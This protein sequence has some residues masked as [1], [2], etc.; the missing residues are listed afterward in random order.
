MS[1]KNSNDHNVNN[2]CEINESSVTPTKKKKIQNKPSP[3]V[4]DEIAQNDKKMTKKPKIAKKAKRLVKT[5]DS[6]K[7][8]PKNDYKR[9]FT[10]T[11]CKKVLYL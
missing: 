11:E 6:G 8:K 5:K 1:K 4:K 10:R 3:K 7:A 9:N 2:D